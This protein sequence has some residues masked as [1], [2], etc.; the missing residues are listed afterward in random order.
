MHHA[1][2]EPERRWWHLDLPAMIVVCLVVLAIE[3][4]IVV[5]HYRRQ[6][7]AIE[8]GTFVP[9]DQPTANPFA[10]DPQPEPEPVP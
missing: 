10:T 4:V 3:A 9:S 6:L 8:L 1:M 7:A 5:S 2:P